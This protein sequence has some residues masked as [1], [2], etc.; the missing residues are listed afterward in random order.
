M[1]G[2]WQV[3][4]TGR[5]TYGPRVSVRPGSTAQLFVRQFALPESASFEN[6]KFG[7]SVCQVL[8]SLWK[9]RVTS[10]VKC[11]VAHESLEAFP[12]HAFTSP[13]IPA[14]LVL[15]DS[16]INVATRKRRDAILEL[17]PGASR[18]RRK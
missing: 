17:V 3:E 18:S 11:W 9:L 14:D 6:N 8:V 12:F 2:R 15:S 1:G 16:T 13:P 5:T 7:E 10:L 4:R